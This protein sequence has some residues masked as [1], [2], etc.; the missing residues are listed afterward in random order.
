MLFTPYSRLAPWAW[1]YGFWRVVT[2][3]SPPRTVRVRGHRPVHAL[4]LGLQLLHIHHVR[5]GP[6]SYYQAIP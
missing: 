3:S 5:H 4:D 2:T 6:N 1:P